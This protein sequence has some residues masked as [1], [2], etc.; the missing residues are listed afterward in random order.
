MAVK[1]SLPKGG[2]NKHDA[3]QMKGKASPETFGIPRETPE[4]YGK[5]PGM[6]GMHNDIG[7]QSG[8]QDTGYIVKKGMGYGESL[9][10][11]FLPPGMDIENQE[12]CDIRSM[13]YKEIISESYPG[14]GWE[15]APRKGE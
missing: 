1:P 2:L 14:D 15:P 13:P 8:F 9:K 12:N 6:G 5:I 3:G 11:N 7:E 10:L 4:D